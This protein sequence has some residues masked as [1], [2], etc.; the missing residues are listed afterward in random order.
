MSNP[1]SQK[2]IVFMW[3]LTVA[4]LIT[5]YNQPSDF[6]IFNDV[7]NKWAGLGTLLMTPVVF[8]YA[9]LVIAGMISLIKTLYPILD[10]EKCS[11]LTK[12]TVAA[13]SV[14]LL[15]VGYGTFLQK[16]SPLDFFETMKRKT[17]IA[18]SDQES[19]LLKY[20]GGYKMYRHSCIWRGDTILYK[21]TK[22]KIATLV[23]DEASN[24][25]HWTYKPM[26]NYKIH[27]FNK[28][29][30]TQDA[31][32]VTFCPEGYSA[33]IQYI[34]NSVNNKKVGDFYYDKNATSDVFQN[35]SII[36]FLFDKSY[37]GEDSV[38]YLLFGI[39]N[40]VAVLRDSMSN[41]YDLFDDE[42]SD[43][44]YHVIEY[45]LN[46]SNGVPI[47]KI[48]VEEK[49]KSIFDEEFF[50]YYDYFDIE[51]KDFVLYHAPY[52]LSRNDTVNRRYVRDDM[53]LSDG[54]CFYN[55]SW[56]KENGYP[57]IEYY[58]V[59]SI[60]DY[61]YNELLPADTLEVGRYVMRNGKYVKEV[62]MQ[63]E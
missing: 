4:N 59:R 20:G 30:F 21:D 51:T 53:S 44:E 15:A 56:P 9:V 46:K 26:V 52:I 33:K 5:F 61:D 34:I 55:D 50:Y 10:G 40:G 7:T 63:K 36:C 41:I 6:S 3:L 37:H 60:R 12:V 13:V 62:Q 24:T 57:V 38:G 32:N 28:D 39:E 25:C 27:F 1:N 2:S 16:Q 35:D 8:V 11:T 22:Q 31:A 14:S 17:S 48:T 29:N 43:N 54:F 42:T 18:Q 19:V 58:T 23:V 49:T 45:H 47:V